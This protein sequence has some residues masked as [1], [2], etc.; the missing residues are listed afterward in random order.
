MRDNKQSVVICGG[1]GFIGG[2]LVGDLVGP[3]GLHAQLDL[4]APRAQHREELLGGRERHPRVVV[5]VGGEHR[6]SGQRGR[7]RDRRGERAVGAGRPD[8]ALAV[9]RRWLDAR[10]RAERP[11][12]LEDS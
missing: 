7:I 4:R 9:V 2:H 10:V 8:E 12:P 1:G 5:A 6:Q 11:A 3:A